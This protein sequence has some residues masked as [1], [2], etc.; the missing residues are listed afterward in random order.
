MSS[1]LVSIIIATYNNESGLIACLASLKEQIYSPVEIIVVLNGCLYDAKAIILKYAEKA[2]VIVNQENLYFARAQNQ[3]IEAAKGEYVFCLNDDCAVGHNHISE[4]IKPFYMDDKIGMV[5]GKIL[6]DDK[7]AI[8]TTGLFLGRSRRPVE[9]GYG[10]KDAGQ[11]ENSGYVF[12]VCAGCGL[13]RRKMLEDIKDKYGYFDN[14]FKMFYEDLDLAWRSHKK[15]WRGYYVPQAIAYHKRGGSLKTIGDNTQPSLSR[16]GT[17]QC[18]VPTKMS[19]RSPSTTPF[20]KF[21]ASLGMVR[22]MVSLSN[23]NLFLS[24]F[25]FTRLSPDLQ[26]DLLKNRW[27]TILKNDSFFGFVFNFPFIFAYELKLRFYMLVKNL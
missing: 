14:R 26:R 7:V 5:T 27:L 16:V 12:G 13:Y 25:Y 10:E 15:G 22:G 6:R 9:R 3:G 18:A 21:L 4:A 24:K 11:F 17:A 1:E 8:D 23:H 20:R 2:K 19:R